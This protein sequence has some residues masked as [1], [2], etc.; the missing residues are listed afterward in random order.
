MENSLRKRL[1]K[2]AYIFYYVFL[3]SIE[4]LNYD[5]EILKNWIDIEI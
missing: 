1:N 5:W 4:G 3:K 2:N